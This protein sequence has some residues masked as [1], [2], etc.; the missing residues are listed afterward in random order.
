MIADGATEL[1]EGV[2]ALENNGQSILFLD[3]I[4]HKAANILKKTL[5][6]EE[7]F[8]TFQ[9]HLGTTTARIQQTELV[10]FLPPKKKSK[11]RFMNLA[12]L[13]K[14]AQMVNY[15]S[16]NPSAAGNEG[17]DAQRLEDKLGWLVEYEDD[18][19]SW[20]VC[21]SIVS[22][23]L[24]FTNEKGV[25][26]GATDELREHLAQLKLPLDRLGQQVHDQLVEVYWQCEHRL[27]HSSHA[28]KRMPV[29]TE[30]LESTLGRFK[31]LQRQHN[32]GSFTSLL[33]AFAALLNPTTPET[34]AKHFKA[35]NNNDVKEWIK[36][37][38]LD[39]STQAKKNKA[40]EAAKKQKL[41]TK[42]LSLE[43][44]T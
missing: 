38:N 17:V 34:I 12:P 41:D 18:L 23:T 32:R 31:Q 27:I 21:Q 3:D 14:W 1:A 44:K 15:H 16:Q 26:R 36:K 39:N 13:L 7:R 22:A 24:V 2:K 29:S 33:A 30:V 43:Q 5:G 42:T 10:H 19:K 6:K 25:Y 9:S 8:V 4:K 28:S 11:C 35:V 20:Q 37:A 40:Y